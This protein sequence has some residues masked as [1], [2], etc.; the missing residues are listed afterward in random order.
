MNQ[1]NFCY[2]FEI[3]DAVPHPSPTHTPTTSHT[4]SSPSPTYHLPHTPY[5]T[6]PTRRW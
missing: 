2:T 5:A 4:L 6:P 3:K 1:S